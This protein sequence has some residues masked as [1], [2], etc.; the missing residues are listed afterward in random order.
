MGHGRP[1]RPQPLQGRANHRNHSNDP[2]QSLLHALLPPAHA[3][4][5]PPMHPWLRIILPGLVLGSAVAACT[6]ENPYIN[7]CG[8]TVVEEANGEECDDG[9]A[10]DDGAACTAECVVAICGDGLVHEGVEACDLGDLNRA[11]GPCTPEC[12]LVSCGDGNLDPGEACDDGPANK[13]EADGQGGCSELCT[14]LPFCGDGIVHSAWEECDDGNLDD[15][16]DCLTTCK[17]ASCGD[18]TIQAGVEMCDDGNTDDTDMCP[19]TCLWATCGDGFT[20]E[21]AEE[22]DDGNEDNSD[23]CLSACL[24]ATCGDGVLQIGVEECDDGNTDPSDGC[25]AECVRDRQVFVSVAA[26]TGEEIMGIAGADARCVVEAEAARLANPER[27]RAWLSDS[28][29]S[30]ATRFETRGARYVLVDGS[31]IADDWDDLTDGQLSHPINAYPDGSEANVAV[32]TS[33]E[34]SGEAVDTGEFCGDW[35]VADDS[36]GRTGYSPEV[37]YFWTFADLGLVCFGIAHFYCFED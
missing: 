14:P 28:K 25:N 21:G 12:T 3:H 26:P 6:E 1:S 24:L 5:L 20:H 13:P 31:V 15:T 27:F 9:D 35:S 16:D 11:E 7:V 34:A 32:W 2:Q 37:D 33:T 10:N 36:Y 19:S 29:S 30:P 22:C 4:T 23:A 18:G 17:L 8:N